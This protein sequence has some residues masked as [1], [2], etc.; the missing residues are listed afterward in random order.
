[1]PF[2]VIL[3]HLGVKIMPSKMEVA[4]QHCDTV[5][6]TKKDILYIV[7]IEKIFIHDSGALHTVQSSVRGTLRVPRTFIFSLGQLRSIERFRTVE[8]VETVVTVYC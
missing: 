2:W 8:T 4:S 3:N 1:M 6:T 5:P 7:K